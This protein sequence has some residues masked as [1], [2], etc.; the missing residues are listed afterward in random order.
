MRNLNVY[1][2]VDADAKVW[3]VESSDIPGLNVEA[4]TFEKLVEIVIDAAPELIQVNIEQEGDDLPN[5]PLNIQH[6]VVATRRVE[7]A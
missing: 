3:F 2:S 7:H 4:T 5:I 6:A 1:V